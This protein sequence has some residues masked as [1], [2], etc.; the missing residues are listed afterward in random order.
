MNVLVI[1]DSCEDIFVYG[2]IIRLS[3]E[4]PVPI[5]QPIK[6]TKMVVWL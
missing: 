3:P 2:N 1:G 5:L 6:E 4:A